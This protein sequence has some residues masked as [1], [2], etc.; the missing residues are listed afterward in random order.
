M[1]KNCYVLDPIRIMQTVCELDGST[2]PYRQVSHVSTRP[3]GRHIAVYKQNIEQ[4]FVVMDGD[5]IV[6]DPLGPESGVSTIVDGAS[7]VSFRSFTA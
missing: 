7:P 4:H 6:F 5:D 2:S 1:R 3:K